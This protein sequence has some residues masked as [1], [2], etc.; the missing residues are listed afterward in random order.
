MSKFGSMMKEWRGMRR[1]SQLDLA[2]A[3]DMSARHL[4]FL[5]TGRAQPSRTMVLRLVQALEMPRPVANQA[6]QRAGYAAY[7]PEVA[8]DSPELAPVRR[9]VDLTLKRH[10]PFPGVAVD[11]HWNIVSANKAGALLMAMNPPKAGMRPNLIEMLINAHDTALVENWAEV[12]AL[13]VIRL[14]GEIIML[15]GDPV[16]QGMA[17]RLAEITR[18]RVDVKADLNLDQAVIPT[19]LRLGEVRLSLFSTIAHFGSVQDVQAGEMRIE[20]MFPM[21]EA[22]E[23]WFELAGDA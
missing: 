15:G 22:T 13:A 23:Q 19:L 14:R 11:R 4:S 20:L 1:F 6:L 9:A 17:D 12:A 18:H 3:A 8:A 5:E 16:L 7:F 10:D 2:M 21:D